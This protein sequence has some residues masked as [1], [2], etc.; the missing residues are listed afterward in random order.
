MKLDILAIAA[1][2]DDVELSCAGTLLAHKSMGKKIGVLDL[3]R[4]ELGTRGTAETRKQEAIDASKVLGLD[5]RENMDFA[6]GFFTNDREHQLAL[7]AAIRRFQ[8]EIILL[9]AIEDRHPD[10]GKGAQLGIDACFFSGLIKIQTSYNN[11]PQPAWRPKA[12]FHF[13]QDRFIKPDL[14]I[15]ITPYW[16]QKAESIRAYKTQFYDPNS[17][18]PNT[19]I[20]SPEFMNFLEAR[21]QEWGHSIGVKYGEGFTKARQIGIRNLFDLI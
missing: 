9:N 11:Q 5:V 10:H 19:Y 21:A 16:K 17:Q 13:I 2:P 18:E 20:S 12:V 4:G 15:D 7:I 6:D 3:T 1:H 8:P 14:V